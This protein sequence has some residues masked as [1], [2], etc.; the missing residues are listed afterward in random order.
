MEINERDMYGENVY[1][2]NTYEVGVDIEAGIYRFV[3]LEKNSSD[4]SGGGL[5]IW[6][7]KEYEDLQYPELDDYKVGSNSLMKVDDYYMVVLEEGYIMEMWG[8][9][10]LAEKLK[11]AL[12]RTAF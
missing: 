1:W 11:Q 8:G 12:E 10:F 9:L 4:S 3:F 7:S 6:K 5:C 2:P